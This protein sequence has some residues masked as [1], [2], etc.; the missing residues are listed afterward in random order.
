MGNYGNKPVIGAHNAALNA[1]ADLYINTVT[2]TTGMV[3]EGDGNVGIGTTTPDNKLHI[4][5][6]SAG[7]VTADANSQ[8]VIE[9]SGVTNINLLAGSTANSAILWGDSEDNDVGFLQYNHA[10][11]FM[12][13]GTNANEW[14]RILSDGKVGIG[15]TSPSGT[16]K[17]D[18]EG[19]V[20]AT[21]YCDEAGNNCRDASAGMVGGT[22]T[23][24]YIPRWNAAGTGL[25]N[26]IISDTSSIANIAGNLKVGASTTENSIKFY[27]VSGDA[28]GSHTT[29]VI[30]ERLYGASD[31]S[32]LL[33]FKGNDPITSGPDRIRYDSVGGHVFQ[34]GGVRY[35][36][37]ATE[38]TT[39]MTIDA[40]GA[41][42]MNYALTSATINTGY[43][44]MELRDDG[45]ADG[46]TTEIP[47][48]DDVYDFVTGSYSGDITGIITNSGSGLNGGCT[49][50]TCTLTFDATDVDGT[51]LSGSGS[52]L[53]VT[54]NCIGNTQLQY[55]TGQHLT[56]SS[57]VTFDTVTTNDG[58]VVTRSVADGDAIW[59]NT[60]SDE[61]HALYNNY[62]NRDSEG[63]FDGMKWN[64][65]DGLYVRTGSA[66]ATSRLEILH[67]SNYI[68]LLNSNVGIGT[69]SP[70]AKL[71]VDGT[72]MADQMD[73]Q[74]SQ[75]MVFNA[76]QQEQE[77]L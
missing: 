57:D 31:V 37:P 13:F 11:N 67:D 49:S 59:F 73:A 40:T 68:N 43:G 1:W 75:D 64:V 58:L 33:I 42:V 38:G 14:V 25:E 4:Q 24:N 22:G 71:D 21:E 66:G 10:S 35:Y 77:M 2:G 8:L 27:G 23:D 47:T 32:E 19:Q 44:A 62:Y 28:P 9:N 50:G 45:I 48:S 53:G 7:A 76:S 55:D 54:G 65:F 6:A 26:S 39:A 17:L 16:L 30:A 34:V 56:T 69:T 63:V 29:T 70:G 51:C 5:A 12:R 41:V 3:V 74:P 52:T 61:N 46:E 20:G 36:D 15:T 18:V 72:L 60:F